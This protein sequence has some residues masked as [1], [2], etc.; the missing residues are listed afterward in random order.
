MAA[1]ALRTPA[2]RRPLLAP[3]SILRTPTPRHLSSSS[4]PS[5]PPSSPAGELLRLLSAAPTW[6]PD[7]ARAVSSTF[8]AS[9]TADVVISVLR[10]IRNPSLAAPF[11]LLA[12]SSSA[13]AP[14]P[15]P[16]DAY[17]AV[18]PFL[19]HDLAALEKVLEEMA[20]LG[21][22]L[23]NQA[24]ADLAAALVRARR[25]DD[26]VLAVAVMRRLKF[27]P[28]FSAYTVL[29]GALA[30]ARRPERALELLRQMQEVGY[31]VGVHLF[32][33]LVRALA[34][35]GQVADALALVDEVKGSCLEPDIVLYN[36]CID[37]FGKAGNVEDRKSVV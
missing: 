25:L 4:P 28:A 9:P 32:T 14:H 21:Y 15:L 3:L 13:S 2:T 8:S 6:T 1:A 24:C 29:I 26:A 30:E 12:S 7:L 36:V 35:E 20:V 10:S 37:C 34:R 31:E 18:L 5:Q 27:R 22:G 33:T 23:P 16:A 17:H 19:H 11:F